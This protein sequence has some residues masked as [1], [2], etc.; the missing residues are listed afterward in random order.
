MQYVQNAYVLEGDRMRHGNLKP[1]FVKYKEFNL[2]DKSVKE[3]AIR[4]KECFK[5]LYQD[6]N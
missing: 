5:H 3:R 2:K 4:L 1:G 6:R